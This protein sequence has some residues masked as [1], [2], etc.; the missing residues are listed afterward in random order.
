M[1][2][3]DKQ[4]IREIVQEEIINILAEDNGFMERLKKF[5]E[6]PVVRVEANWGHRG[7]SKFT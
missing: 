3:E 2:D 6:I 5:I 7:P 4:A 1:T